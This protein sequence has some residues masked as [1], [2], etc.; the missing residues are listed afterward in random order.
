MRVFTRGY[1]WRHVRNRYVICIHMLYRLYASVYNGAPPLPTYRPGTRVH[2][3]VSE[4]IRR[5][6]RAGA[7]EETQLLDSGR[8]YYLQ[9]S[10]GRVP[11]IPRSLYPTTG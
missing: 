2:A 9:L 7:R 8:V 10:L 4:C 6:V 5:A 11:R 1:F 3:Y